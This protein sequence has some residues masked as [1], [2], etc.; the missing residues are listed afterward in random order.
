MNRRTALFFFVAPFAPTACGDDEASGG[1]GGSGFATTNV[2]AST[3]GS[4]GPLPERFRVAF[5]SCAHQDE[6]KPVLDLARESKP[7]L[8]IFLGD[9]IYAD[10]TNMDVMRS[11]YEKLAASPEMIALRAVVPVVATWD[12]HDYG[13]N[14]AG[15]E[16]S[17]KV[18]SRALF[19][20]FWGEP[21]DSARRAH[22]GIYTSYLLGEAPRRLQVIL[23]DTRTFRDPLDDTTDP[24]FKNDY[25]PTAD[26]SRTILG[27]AQ[28]AWL[29]RELLEPAEVRLVCTSIQIGHSY[30]GWE[31]WTNMP[32]ERQRMIDLVRTTQANGVVFL[33]GDVHWA[34]LSR[35][36]V[37]G[38]YPLHD[39]TSSG[40][41]E[42]WPTIEPND[43][44]VGE[45]V[46]ENNYGFVDIDW[47]ETGTK[48][49][50]GIVDEHAA[51]RISRSIGLETLA[52]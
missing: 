29:E 45:P 18:E 33:S 38:G 43:N 23:L 39:L 12:D 4:G 48:L 1:A 6:P 40:I 42:S 13:A 41:T 25:Q 31:S 52:F 30:N 47:A 2:T 19:L 11:E 7:D 34:E 28:W 35:L 8:F 17:K 16:Y 51:V 3:V 24:G 20:D 36:E 49:T 10:T 37:P 14:D 44:R 32:H 26:T 50:L 22:D 9:N 15:K 27:E 5:G 46:R 21:A